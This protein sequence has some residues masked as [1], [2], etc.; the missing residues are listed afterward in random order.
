MPAAEAS[1][2]PASPFGEDLPVVVGHRGAP[3]LAPE[4]TPE[5]FAAAAAAGAGWVELDVRPAADGLVVHHDPCTV[6]GTPLVERSVRALR[7]LGVWA[8][9][10]VLDGLP[11]GLGVDAEVKNAPGEPG[12][13]PGVVLAGR[14][15]PLL[16]AAAGERPVCA[17][18]FHPPTVAALVAHLDGGGAGSGGG[19]GAGGGIPV[20]LLAGPR[21]RPASAL[22]LARDLGGRLVCPHVLTLGLGPAYVAA[23]HRAGLAVLVWTVDRPARAR[24]LAAAGVDAICTND[25]GGIAAVLAAPVENGPP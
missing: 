14:V 2:P 19:G 9:D 16:R 6:D 8:L 24:A 5:A 13:L 10:E 17:T 3:R 22:R 23:A 7:A 1:S 21:V 11:D 20:G 12:A 15:A 18:S 25:P 4:N